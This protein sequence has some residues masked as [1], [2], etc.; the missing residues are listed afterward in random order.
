M[1]GNRPLLGFS[2]RALL[3]SAICAAWLA[4]IAAFSLP[5]A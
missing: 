3:L 1:F 2:R 4:R 5:I